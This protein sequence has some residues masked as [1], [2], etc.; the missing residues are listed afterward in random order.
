MLYFVTAARSYNFT[1]EKDASRQ[2]EGLTVHYL[3]PSSVD[4]SDPQ[5]TGLFPLQCPAPLSLAP[6]FGLAPPAPA[7][8][9]GGG[10]GGPSAVPPLPGV[11][12]L[13]FAQRPGKGNR[14]V[15]TC[16]DAK[17][18]RSVDFAKIMKI[19]ATQP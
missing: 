9:P 10:T 2:V 18:V 16:V 1:D 4:D 11:Y 6:A 7:T 13:T 3:D 12:E 8:H 5:R 19:A 15:L 14:P 17:L